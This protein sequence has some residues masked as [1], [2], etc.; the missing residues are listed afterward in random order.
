VFVDERPERVVEI[1]NTVGLTGAQLHGREPMS[2]ARMI[3]Q[4]VGYLIQAFPAGDPALSSAGNSPADAIL[5][6]SPTPGSGRVFDWTSGADAD[7][8]VINEAAARALWPGRSPL[9]QWVHEGPDGHP[10]Q[11]VGVVAD[12]VS[13]RFDRPVEPYLYRPLTADRLAADITVVTRGRTDGAAAAATLRAAWRDLDANLPPAAVQTMEERMALPLWPSRV[14][15]AFFATCGTLA[16]VLVTVGLFGVTYYAVTQRTR[17]FGIRLALGAT[18]QD[19]R[20]WCLV[21]CA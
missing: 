20:G 17:E 13:F 8:V 6:D 11:V 1:V 9:G 4:R 14:G 3:R 16:V 19:L 7:T 5:V 21:S 12:V 15:A 10:R 18:A 2:E